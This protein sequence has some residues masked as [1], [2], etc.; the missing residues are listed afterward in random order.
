MAQLRLRYVNEYVDRTGKVRRY[1]RK[2]GKQYGPLPGE[3]GSEEFM[4]AYQA[5]LA[6]EPAVKVATRGLE[7]SLGRLIVEFYGSGMFMNLKPSSRRIYRCVLDP[8]SRDHGHRSVALMTPD[9]IERVIQRIGQEHPAMGNLTRAVVKRL[10][11]YAIKTKWRQDNPATGI[12]PFKVGT[13]HTWTDAELRQFEARWH[14]GTRQ[15]LAYALLLYTGQ[16]VGDVAK[17]HRSDIA[18]GLIHVVQEKTGAVVYIPI[19]PELDLAM[20]A[21][22]A[23]GLTLIGDAQGRPLKRA[24]LSGLMRAAIKQAGLPPRCVSHG[25]RKAMMRRLAEN[26]ATVKQI[27]SISGHKT[28]RE[29]ER[30][31]AAADQKSL[32]RAG[33]R[34]LRGA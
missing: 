12:D 21:W 9:A 32:A 14:P 3:V 15:R 1:F 7:G 4:G 28:L 6:S 25:L 19:E 5:F 23:S 13:H 16:R 22:P 26:D 11:R 24:A 33:M 29:V 27:A 20:K 34:K 17:M 18:D 8:L 31:T 2:G 10:M 30:Y